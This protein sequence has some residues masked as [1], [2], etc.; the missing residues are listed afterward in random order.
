MNRTSEKFMHSNKL[1][2]DFQNN[3]SSVS[4]KLALV[5][6]GILT[7]STTEGN[8]FSIEHSVYENLLVNRID[9]DKFLNKRLYSKLSSKDKG[10]ANFHLQK[11]IKEWFELNKKSILRYDFKTLIGFME[12]NFS[13]SAIYDNGIENKALDMLKE[14]LLKMYSELESVIFIL[15]SKKKFPKTII[16]FL[17]ELRITLLYDMHYFEN[18]KISDLRQYYLLL[19]NYYEL[20]AILEEENYKKHSSIEILNDFAKDKPQL[21]A[22]KIISKKKQDNKQLFTRA[23]RRRTARLVDL[24]EPT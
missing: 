9:Y 17:K 5:E 14:N 10:E 20:H 21:N 1:S 7:L 8:Q 12:Y 15:C 22:T 18:Y 23:D 19:E 4:N 3:L 13:K 6:E 2:N 24:Q 11:F 16:K